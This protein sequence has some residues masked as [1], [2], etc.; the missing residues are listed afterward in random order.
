MNKKQAITLSLVIALGVI[1][2]LVVAGLVQK[3]GAPLG[4]VL[5]QETGFRYIASTTIRLV[6]PSTNHL[7]VGQSQV[8]SL[9]F[10]TNTQR[11]YLAITATNTLTAQYFITFNDVPCAA[12]TSG[13]TLF[14]TSTS[15]LEFFGAK[16]Y[17][18]TIRVCSGGTA[19]GSLNAMQANK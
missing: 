17:Q 12:T 14:G 7:Q 3:T 19:T 16:N 9:L 1:F 11:T 8:P 2:G 15:P 10:G 6:P 4:V 13:I 18:G 5:Q